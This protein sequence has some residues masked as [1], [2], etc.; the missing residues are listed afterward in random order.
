MAANNIKS[1]VNPTAFS[2]TTENFVEISL[3][4]KKNVDQ[5]GKFSVLNPLEIFIVMLIKVVWVIQCFVLVMEYIR[6]SGA[7]YVYLS[8]ILELV[9]QFKYYTAAAQIR[10]RTCS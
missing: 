7:C 10:V 2:I 8:S 1:S 9:H 5:R 6:G 4:L 3:N